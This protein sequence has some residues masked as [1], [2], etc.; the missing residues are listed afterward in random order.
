MK[1]L[2]YFFAFY[3]VLILSGNDAL[4]RIKFFNDQEDET[5]KSFIT[6]VNHVL[7]KEAQQRGISLKLY[8]RIFKNIQFDFRVVQYDQQQPEYNKNLVE[9][10]HPRMNFSKVKYAMLLAKRYNAFFSSIERKYGIDRSYLLAIWSM[11]TIFGNY[12]GDFY[13][14]HAL[15]SLIYEGRRAKFFKEQLF[16]LLELIANKVVSEK[17][18][19]GS[20]A[21]GM[22]NFQ[23]I[24]TTLKSYGV[25]LNK[26]RAINVW[27][28][29]E[30]IASAANYLA[31]LGWE[32]DASWG[33]EIFL[34]SRF[35]GYHFLNQ[36]STFKDLM[37]TGILLSRPQD[38]EKL[39]EDYPVDL[40]MP[41]GHTG[42][43]YILYNNFKH[44]MSWNKS[45]NY[46]LTVGILRNNIAA[47]EILPAP[48]L[49]IK[50]YKPL[51]IKD[52]IELQR[53]LNVLNF[54]AGIAD[55]ILGSKTRLA[56]QR[57]QNQIDYF[58]SD[59]Y[60][61]HDFMRFMRAYHKAF[62][63]HSDLEMNDYAK[64]YF[65]IQ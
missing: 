49:N 18:V 33:Q 36:S 38:Y 44:L 10:I 25:D 31:S 34:P 4:S 65:N 1:Y 59:G 6:F 61:S 30:S 55:G 11:E 43:I 27:E 48:K 29:E 23:F 17:Q 40:R 19:Y 52:L 41:L 3:I 64:K 26:D 50:L 7:R 37:D 56:I 47:G 2:K 46:A 21:G 35:Q 57:A 12:V 45:V 42:P 13:I 60:P 28:I 8:D 62:S 9:Y 15:A 39:G 16:T 58:V 20:W 22:G 32:R 54:N 63:K 51:K 24:P 53:I 14:P 5:N